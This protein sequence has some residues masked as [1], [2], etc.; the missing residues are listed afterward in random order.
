MGDEIK[1]FIPTEINKKLIYV[2]YICKQFEN[3]LINVRISLAYIN[4]YYLNSY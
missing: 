2:P 1:I 4:N 3:F